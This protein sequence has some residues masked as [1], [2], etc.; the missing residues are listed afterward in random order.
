MTT[1]LSQNDK[2][3]SKIIEVAESIDETLKDALVNFIHSRKGNQKF[4]HESFFNK[5]TKDFKDLIEKEM[6]MII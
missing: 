3:L 6:Q 5:N 4:T 1:L 2:A